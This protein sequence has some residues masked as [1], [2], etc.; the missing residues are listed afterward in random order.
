MSSCL[1]RTSLQ[2]PSIFICFFSSHWWYRARE[3][4]VD[5]SSF[6]PS[7]G[8]LSFCKK[9]MYKKPN[10]DGKISLWE[11]TYWPSEWVFDGNS[12]ACSNE[13]TVML[14]EAIGKNWQHPFFSQSHQLNFYIFSSQKKSKFGNSNGMFYDCVLRAFGNVGGFFSSSSYWVTIS[15]YC[16]TTS[17]EHRE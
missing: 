6:F 1:F 3:I 7:S 14:F 9:K 10:D 16:L 15:N 12:L 17:M 4:E 2:I 13:F 5:N 8:Y 11:W